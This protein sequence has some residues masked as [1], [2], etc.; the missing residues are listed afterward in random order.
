MRKPREVVSD[1]IPF[2]RTGRE[3]QKILAYPGLKLLGSRRHKLHTMWNYLDLL[4]VRGRR[5][6]YLVLETIAG[7]TSVCGWY[8]SRRDAQ[9]HL[10]HGGYPELPADVEAMLKA[11]GAV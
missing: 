3:R 7:V 9:H 8:V 6:I 1:P 11:A 5:R 4:Q 2:R 10:D